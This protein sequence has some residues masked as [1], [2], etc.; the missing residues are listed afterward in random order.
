MGVHVAFKNEEDPIK[1]E[2]NGVVT[3]NISPIISQWGFFKMLKGS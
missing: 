3:V 2:G 1:S